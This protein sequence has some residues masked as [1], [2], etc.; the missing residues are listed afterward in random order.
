MHADQDASQAAAAGFGSTSSRFGDTS[1]SSPGPGRY[2][3]CTASVHHGSRPTAHTY[4]S[5]TQHHYHTTAA[6][7]HACWCLSLQWFVTCL[8]CCCI[9]LCL[10]ATGKYTA[11][12]ADSIAADAARKTAA[13]SR[14]GVF[15]S[16]A[17][18]FMSGSAGDSSPVAAAAGVTAAGSAA[19][20]QL[21]PGAYE[22]D[23]GVSTRVAAA[24]A[25][26]SPVS[27]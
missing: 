9:V 17:E 2:S 27:L 20:S 8:L 10:C 26:P 23:C 3:C 12:Q 5:S 24:A 1:S 16:A 6:A 14:R 18:R 4:P 25:R 7:R 13:A 21:G 15:G 22:V 19:S 11:D